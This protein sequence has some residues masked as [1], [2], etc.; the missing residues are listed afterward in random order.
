MFGESSSEDE[1]DDTGHCRGH[2]GHCYRADGGND[3][4]SY[5][6][7]LIPY[8]S[9]CAFDILRKILFLPGA[10]HRRNKFSNFCCDLMQNL[11]S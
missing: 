3:P 10:L 4:G 6:M 11:L 8:L 2:K 9:Y 1:G 7:V 5:K